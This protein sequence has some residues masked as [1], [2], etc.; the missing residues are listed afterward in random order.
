MSLTWSKNAMGIDHV[1]LFESTDRKRVRPDQINYDY[2]DERDDELAPMEMVV[3]SVFSF[4]VGRSLIRND[5]T[6]G[7]PPFRRLSTHQLLKQ[8]LGIDPIPWPQA[9]WIGGG[10]GNPRHDTITVAL[11]PKSAV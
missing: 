10:D 6:G 9:P 8:E 11:S 1:F 2:F 4:C 5:R 3:P 7:L